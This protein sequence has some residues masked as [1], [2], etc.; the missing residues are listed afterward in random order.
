MPHSGEGGGGSWEG[1]GGICV[2][3]SRLDSRLSNISTIQD[4]LAQRCGFAYNCDARF[5][6]GRS[7]SGSTVM[8]AMVTQDLH[9]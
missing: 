8:V 7:S 9:V 4:I 3:S 6:Q 2:V 5:P 1:G